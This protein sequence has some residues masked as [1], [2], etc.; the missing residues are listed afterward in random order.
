[1]KRVS[2][3][4]LLYRC[5]LFDTEWTSGLL[6]FPICLLHFSSDLLDIDM[7]R[8]EAFLVSRVLFRRR[9]GPHCQNFYHFV[10]LRK[11]EKNFL[12]S[13][14]NKERIDILQQK[15]R[16]RL[17]QRQKSGDNMTVTAF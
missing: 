17:R 8:A 4:A 16:V 7:Y 5:R 10:V 6:Y 3:L 2:L 15:V 12:L 1:M 11:A 13:P 14:R 9:R